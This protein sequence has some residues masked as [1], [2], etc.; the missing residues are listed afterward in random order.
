MKTYVIDRGTRRV[1]KGFQARA[2]AQTWLSMTYDE[3]R[4]KQFLLLDAP[5]ITDAIAQA[6]AALAKPTP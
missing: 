6:R 2:A 4:H 1:L 5:S 3:M